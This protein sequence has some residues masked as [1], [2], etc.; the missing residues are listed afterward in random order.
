MYQRIALIHH[1]LIID[2]NYV[3]IHIA[4]NFFFGLAKGIKN[5]T[6]QIAFVHMRPIAHSHVKQATAIGAHPS[7]LFYSNRSIPRNF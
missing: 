6:Q 1:W 2:P 3:S 4:E 5:N 7:V